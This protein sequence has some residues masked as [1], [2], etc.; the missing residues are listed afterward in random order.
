V[1]RGAEKLAAVGVNTAITGSIGPDPAGW[2]EDTF[3]A[4]VDRMADIEATPW[5]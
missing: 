2:L 4:V 3:G 1:L 5:Y